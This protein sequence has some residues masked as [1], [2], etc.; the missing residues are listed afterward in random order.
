MLKPLK[1]AKC[2][3]CI[4]LFIFGLCACQPKA[5]NR[6]QTHIPTPEEEAEYVWSNLQD[7]AFF[8]ENGYTVSFPVGK[9]IE[10]LKTKAKN[11]ELTDEDFNKLSAYLRDSVYQKA[12]YLKGQEKVDAEMTVLNGMIEDLEKATRNW[13]FQSFDT[14]T[15]NLTLYG[16]GG[17]YNNQNG[18]ILLFTTP[19]GDFK[20]YEKAAPTLIHEIVHIGIEN[21]IV[22]AFQVPHTLKERIVDHIVL[23]RFGE[24]LPEYNLQEM[25]ETRIDDYLTDKDSIQKLD[26]FVQEI[27]NAVP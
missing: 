24:Q 27:M 19:K 16:P 8:E 14:Y 17:S 11:K 9:L 12:D 22:Q 5:P 18:H 13:N 4:L 25:G 3:L 1:T 23:L 10:E 21:P 6:I 20:Q 7:I 2:L 15:V 26:E